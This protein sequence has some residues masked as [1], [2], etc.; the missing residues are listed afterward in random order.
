MW[1]ATGLVHTLIWQVCVSWP[2]ALLSV[3]MGADLREFLGGAAIGL[4]AASVLNWPVFGALV[5]G[6]AGQCAGY[7]FAVACA[8]GILAGMAVL[9]RVG[10]KS[11]L[12]L[13]CRPQSKVYR[14]FKLA[15]APVITGWLVTVVA[16][17]SPP[18]EA[19][20][21]SAYGSLFFVAENASLFACHE[22]I[23]KRVAW[24]IAFSFIVGMLIAVMC[25]FEVSP[26]MR[27]FFS[28]PAEAPPVPVMAVV[29]DDVF[30]VVPPTMEMA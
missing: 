9:V 3:L 1:M 6:A 20:P 30:D 14:F 21:C 23:D 26:S 29:H 12:V 24:F 27:R 16:F 17:F 7:Y 18:Q 15:P 13:R 25:P 4:L 8:L 5:G 10:D 2:A 19:V 22:T 11:E 28:P